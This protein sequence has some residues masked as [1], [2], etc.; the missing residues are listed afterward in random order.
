MLNI[1]YLKHEYFYIKFTL[2]KNDQYLYTLLL[3]FDI[4]GIKVT[5][6]VYKGQTYEQS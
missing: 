5:K 2:I 1:A 4:T 6:Y 3:F